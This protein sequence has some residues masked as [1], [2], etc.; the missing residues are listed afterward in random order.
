MKR[1]SSPLPEAL[2]AGL[3]LATLLLGGCGGSARPT[4]APPRQQ[5]ALNHYRKGLLGLD[6]KRYAESLKEFE[7]AVRLDPQNA[8]FRYQLGQVHYSLGEWD[9]AEAALREVTKLDPYNADARL[10]LG[11][12][13]SEKGQRQAALDEFRTVLAN[14]NYSTPEKAWVNVA[15]LYDQMGNPEEA[16]GSYHKALDANPHYARAHYGLAQAL[17]KL[18]RLKEAIAEY[19]IAAPDYEDSSEFHYRA[20]LACFRSGLKEQAKQ[21][22]GMVVQKSPGTTDAVKAEELLKLI[23]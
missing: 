15:L 14:R 9:A 10:L 6:Q 17:D 23:R 3:F 4:Q 2:L 19:E 11:A 22:L 8:A 18:D 5:E 12:V 20:G 1:T 13:L 16:I 7:E 21:H